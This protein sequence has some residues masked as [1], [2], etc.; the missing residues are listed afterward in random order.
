MFSTG[1][2]Y[3]KCLLSLK[4]ARS[5]TAPKAVLLTTMSESNS[6]SHFLETR[7]AEMRWEAREMDSQRR[8][9][10]PLSAPRALDTQHA[11]ACTHTHTYRE[12]LPHRCCRAWKM[13]K[14][15][16]YA[17]WFLN[18]ECFDFGFATTEREAAYYLLHYWHG[19]RDTSACGR[20]CACEP[21][22]VYL[23]F[24][25]VDVCEPKINK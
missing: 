1:V 21:A 23:C 13:K 11:H 18:Q 16:V 14:P 3:Q 10:N 6:G 2:W 24:S 5:E 12:V 25:K 20:A 4:I 9:A 8:L 22:C 19:D 7:R 15:W 17:F